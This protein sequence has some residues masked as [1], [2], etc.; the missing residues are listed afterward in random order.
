MLGFTMDFVETFSGAD[1]VTEVITQRGFGQT[2]GV[3]IQDKTSNVWTTQEVT[4][5]WFDQAIDGETDP[6]PQPDGGDDNQPDDGPQPD[7]DDQTDPQEPDTA[8]KV[9]LSGFAAAA[10][11]AS[12]LF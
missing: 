7:G 9:I 1:H 10:I 12:I 11:S 8:A 5:N 2:A 6:D 3:A 4:I